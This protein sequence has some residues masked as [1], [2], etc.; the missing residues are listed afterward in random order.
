MTQAGNWAPGWFRD[1]TGRHDHRWWDGGAWTGHVADAGI[2]GRDELPSVEV[3]S[4]SVPAKSRNLTGPNDAVALSASIVGIAALPLAIVPGFGLVLPVIAI[5]L[6]V[7]ARTRVR[8]LGSRGDSLAI[9]GLAAGVGALLIAVVVTVFAAVLLSGSGGEL[10]DAFAAYIACL[11]TSTP[12]AC[13][14]LLEESLARI[15]G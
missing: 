9:G 12:A 1:P 10:A 11:E 14:I 8:T 3:S 2:A 5:I 4:A 13:R 7:I 6:A 15:A